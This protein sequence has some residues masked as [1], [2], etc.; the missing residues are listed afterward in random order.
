MFP[1]FGSGLPK[2]NLPLASRCKTL[3]ATADG[4]V[5]AEAVGSLLLADLNHV[6]SNHTPVVAM[7]A[8][9]AVNQVMSK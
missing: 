7:L 1:L 5:R 6:A 2:K 8:G 9:S 3:D 4:Y